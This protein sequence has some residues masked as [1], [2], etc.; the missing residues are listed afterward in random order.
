MAGEPPK[1]QSWWQTLP[2]IL[3]AVA[4]LITASTGLIVALNNVGVFSRDSESVSPTPTPTIALSAASTPA[5]SAMVPYTQVDELEQL[6]KAANIE[7][8]TGGEA[9]RK[10]VRGYFDSPEAPYYLLTLSCLHVMENLRLK[11]TGY[12]DMIDKYYSENADDSV[13]IPV[14]GELNLERL[15][16]A[17][18]KAQ[19]DYHSDQARTFEEIAGSR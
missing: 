1:S 12:L 9:G 8:S 5:M 10:K 16:K 6:L 15:K 4:A 13:Y 3:T 19:Q 2:G 17:M 11:Q 7:L 18:I 14:N